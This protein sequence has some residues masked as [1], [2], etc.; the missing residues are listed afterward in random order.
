M[1]SN[2][3]LQNI[4]RKYA[5]RSLE[6]NADE[7]TAL[8]ND[9]KQW[10]STCYVSIINSGS[11]AK[12]TSISISSDIDY[13]I[14]LSNNCN[15][16]NGGLKSIYNSLHKLLDLK[17]TTVRQQNV[18]IRIKIGDLEID[19]TPARKQAGNT[20]DHCLYVS[21]LDTWKQ[22]NIQRHITDISSSGRQNEI[23]L[24][25]IWR[26]LCNIDFPSIYLEY[27]VINTL[28]GKSKNEL[29]L[30]NNFMFILRELS[31]ETSNPINNRI[32]DPANSNNILSDLLN[33]VEKDAI[34][35]AAKISC[36]KKYWKEI[37]W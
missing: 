17:Y 12:G 27:L 11:R 5:S 35:S 29:E 19:I 1:D 2:T 26:E 18:S 3:Y 14:S 15:S 34:I 13:L 33:S 30:C 21:K 4:L 28:A 32:V 16:N 23:K 6:P 36:E 9:L 8:M 31:K 24:L 20:N 37:I 7:I 22:T 10:A 25:K